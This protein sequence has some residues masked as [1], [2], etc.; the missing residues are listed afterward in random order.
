METPP[1]P[2]DPTR[3]L[4]H[5]P[6]M[7]QPRS[8]IEPLGNAGGFSGASFWRFKSELGT[9][10]LKAWPAPRSLECRRSSI[11][12]IHAYLFDASASDAVLGPILPV[13]FFN[14]DRVTFVE[15]SARFWELVPWLPGA[16]DQSQPRDLARTR[17]AFAALARL[18]RALGRD[19]M[20]TLTSGMN[21]RMES[22]DSLD[23]F[24]FNELEACIRA[25]QCEQAA[26]AW[27]LL[28]RRTLKALDDRLVEQ[29]NVLLPVQ[30]CL[31]DARPDHFL[32]DGPKL[33]GLID[34]AAMKFD[35][36]AADLGRLLPDWAGNDRLVRDAALNA[37]VAVRPL[38]NEE[39]GAIPVFEQAAAFFAGES[40]IRWHYI[41]GRRFDDPVAPRLGLERSVARMIDL[42]GGRLIT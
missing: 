36:V 5:Y 23:A 22:L 8:R 2:L 28:A 18:H 33:T 9:L 4:R 30:P 19:A 14:S 39:L 37:Y 35:T 16:P 3:A 12:K 31:G 13:P 21:A 10:G 7:L 38:S 24:G 17:I 11:R 42:F 32:F 40:W 27:I 25:D 15:E 1:P 34:F 20:S 6:R 41:E 26:R 29:I